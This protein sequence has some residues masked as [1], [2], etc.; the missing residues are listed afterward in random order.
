MSAVGGVT[1]PDGVDMEKLP[2]DLPTLVS[3]VLAGEPDTL[4]A[5]SVILNHARSVTGFGGGAV[6]RLGDKGE[7]EVRT[8]QGRASTLAVEAFRP[9][10]GRLA[11]VW[12]VT[13]P[14][15]TASAAL[16]SDVGGTNRVALA[17]ALLPVRT[18]PRVVLLLVRSVPGS[19]SAA[20]ALPRA[21]V[22]KLRDLARVAT[23]LLEVVEEHARLRKE[24]VE[25]KRRAQD[26]RAAV[27]T[28]DHF[29]A[30]MSHDLRTPLSAI[31]GFAQLLEM[32]RLDPGQRKNVKHILRSGR[33]LQKLLTQ[34][35][36]IAYAAAGKLTL[37]LQPVDV[38]ALVRDCVSM[39]QVDAKQAGVK[40]T[41]SP[42]P[43][44]E[45]LVISTDV[46]RLSQILLN[47]LSNAIKVS[48][49]RQVVTVSVTA[50]DE[51][52]SISVVDRGPG[53][54]PELLSRLFIPFAA[55]N[56]DSDAEAALGLPLSHSLATALGGSLTVD[57][58]VGRG[59]RFT[60]T[61]PRR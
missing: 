44:S 31:L 6:L 17:Y 19:L 48:T 57:S 59:A 43:S 29:L 28:R 26:A 61:V 8:S 47:L 55:T 38:G 40:V 12:T 7:L 37:M 5:Q 10:H 9:G 30:R 16:L 13:D 32:E 11:A 21:E 54:P 49:K 50:G 45:P 52:V 4:T 41:I 2:L 53:I 35:I 24:I 23:P 56:P 60:V 3:Q 18:M 25:M 15:P 20:E 14:E 36:E 58:E 33:R 27:R 42:L 1:R 34:A 39:V 22:E 51:T 46:Q